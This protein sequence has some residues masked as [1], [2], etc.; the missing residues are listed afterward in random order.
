MPFAD[1]QMQ[2]MHAFADGQMQVMHVYADGQTEAMHALLKGTCR[3]ET[4]SMH[5]IAMSRCS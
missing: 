3:P 5:C 2:V 4:C 1:G